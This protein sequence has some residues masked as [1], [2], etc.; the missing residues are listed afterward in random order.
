MNDRTLFYFRG[1][2][3]PGRS[4][5]KL[6]MTKNCT[7]EATLSKRIVRHGLEALATNSI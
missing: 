5:A 7:E 6:G 1:R 3:M 4:L 2:L